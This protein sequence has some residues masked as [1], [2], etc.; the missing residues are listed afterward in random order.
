MATKNTIKGKRTDD[1]QFM[2]TSPQSGHVLDEPKRE[3]E[4][5]ILMI[6][7]LVFLL[8]SSYTKSFILEHVKLLSMQ[9][10]INRVF[11]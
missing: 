2:I 5:L 1:R 4:K 8:F 10:R 7:L 3:R 11:S 9:E 6:P